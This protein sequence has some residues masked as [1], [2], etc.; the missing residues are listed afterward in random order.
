MLSKILSENE[1]LAEKWKDSAMSKHV[2]T[3]RPKTPKTTRQR[4][5]PDDKKASY[6]SPMAYKAFGP[7]GASRFVIQDRKP[8]QD[9][10]SLDNA[11]KKGEKRLKRLIARRDLARNNVKNDG[12]IELA[13]LELK[14]RKQESHNNWILMRLGPIRKRM[15]VQDKRFNT[16]RENETQAEV[17]QVKRSQEQHDFLMKTGKELKTRPLPSDLGVKRGGRTGNRLMPKRMKR[18]SKK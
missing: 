7:D 18:F 15:Q 11:L 16:L 12:G 4:E 8:E 17:I 5:I 6:K 3:F 13:D 2:R 1:V 10:Y 14:I 9:A